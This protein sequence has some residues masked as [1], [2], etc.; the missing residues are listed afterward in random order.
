MLHQFTDHAG[1]RWRAETS[2]LSHEAGGLHSV[3]VWFTD[4]SSGWHI[5]GS[6]NPADVKQPTDA[7]VLQ[8]L[9]QALRDKLE[10]KPIVMKMQSNPEMFHINDE[11]YVQFVQ[12][13][14]QQ[15]RPGYMASE[16]L[17]TM[18]EVAVRDELRRLG[19]DDDQVNA[20]V[21]L[22]RLTYNGT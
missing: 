21:A 11:R 3:G 7:R 15:G 1:H 6:L 5:Y 18:D 2:G 12:D 13:P 17:I 22:A 20:A 4:E 10:D 8:A 19:F 14:E 9:E 16:Q